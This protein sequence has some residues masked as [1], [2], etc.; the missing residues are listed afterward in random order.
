MAWLDGAVNGMVSRLIPAGF[1]PDEAFCLA[2]AAYIKE[3]KRAKGVPRSVL[4]R[5]QVSLE[6]NQTLKHLGPLPMGPEA[7]RQRIILWERV[8]GRGSWHESIDPVEIYGPEAGQPAGGIVDSLRLQEIADDAAF[9]KLYYVAPDAGSSP[10]DLLKRGFQVMAGGNSLFCA[11]KIRGNMDQ[12]DGLVACTGDKIG[13]FTIQSLAASGDPMPGDRIRLFSSIRSVAFATIPGKVTL[14]NFELFTA[15]EAPHPVMMISFD[16]EEVWDLRFSTAPVVGHGYVPYENFVTGFHDDYQR[17]YGLNKPAARSSGIVQ[18]TAA[19]TSMGSTRSGHTATLLL[20]GKVLVAGGDS[21]SVLSSAEFYDPSTGE[22]QNAATMHAAR[23]DH[24]ATLL[25]NGTVL[26]AGGKDDNWAPLANAERYDPETGMWATTSSMATARESHTATLLPNGSIL[27]VGGYSDYETSDTAEL[28]DPATG[29]WSATESMGSARYGHSATLLPNGLVLVCGGQN[30]DDWLD[31]CELYDTVNGTWSTTAAM[32][33]EHAHHTATLL[34]NG[35]VLI[36][37]GTT[38][39]LYDPDAGTWSSTANLGAS[40]SGHTATLLSDG[41]VLVLG[42]T[43]PKTLG[44]PD[45]DYGVG[46]SEIYDPVR[47]S[48]TPPTDMAALRV[49]HTATLLADGTVMICGGYN[50]RTQIASVEFWA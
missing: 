16:N 1:T 34:T 46:S 14:P 33:D 10:S 25:P 20:N 27:V 30:G 15:A 47:E 2:Q 36:T 24:T 35:K 42:G 11:F 48:W 29:D 37:G 28:F 43:Q 49:N 39:E 21:E 31:S 19:V 7:H 4:E 45:T 40:R 9:S 8:F 26:I 13:L 18:E 5:Q 44:Q 17:W 41:T 22:W 3:S 12:H 23:T 50:W 38:A 6:I 32:R